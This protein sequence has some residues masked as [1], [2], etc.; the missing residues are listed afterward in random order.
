M[1]FVGSSSKG[2]V[3]I[4]PVYYIYIYTHII[5]FFLSS[6]NGMSE[7]RG[8]NLSQSDL[9]ERDKRREWVECGV[10]GRV[11]YLGLAIG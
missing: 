2:G 8:R 11:Q 10:W 3:V 9:T 5:I 4:S 7:W 6:P 1:L